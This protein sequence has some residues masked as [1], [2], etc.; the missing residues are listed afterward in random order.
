MLWKGRRS[1]WKSSNKKSL[2]VWGLE[3]GV[4][5]LESGALVVGPAKSLSVRQVEIVGGPYLKRGS[6]PISHFPF[7][8]FHF[9]FFIVFHFSL[10]AGPRETVLLGPV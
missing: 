4:W 6:F 3:S 1:S 10:A 2:V 5:S 9:S 8:I 7:S